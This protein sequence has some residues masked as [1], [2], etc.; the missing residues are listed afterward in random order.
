[1]KWRRSRSTRSG[2]GWMR[3]L[4]GT[5]FRDGRRSKREVVWPRG[6]VVGGRGAGRWGRWLM[7]QRRAWRAR[8]GTQSR[9][10]NA[11][12]PNPNKIACGPPNALRISR[13]AGLSACALYCT[14][15][16]RQLGTKVCT[17]RVPHLCGN[18]VPPPVASH[19]AL[20]SPFRT[21]LQGAGYGWSEQRPD[22]HP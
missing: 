5:Q 17:N 19:S 2:V 9:E 12:D 10:A 1:M 15:R 13:A 20:S 18:W 11:P 7:G 22:G 8:P 6:V 16:L 21:H 14:R 4:G 3:M